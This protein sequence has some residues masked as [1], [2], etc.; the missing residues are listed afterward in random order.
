MLFI[1]TSKLIPINTQCDFIGNVYQLRKAKISKPNYYLLI[2][3]SE[4]TSVPGSRGSGG[5]AKFD[6]TAYAIMQLNNPDESVNYGEFEIPL[7]P[8]PVYNP[9]ATEPLPATVVLTLSD[10]REERAG[11]IAKP[12]SK[13]VPIRPFKTKTMPP[14]EEK[15]DDNV[16][17]LV[18]D[19]IQPHAGVEINSSDLIAIYV[20]SMRFIPNICGIIKVKL[21]GYTANMECNITEKQMNP[22]KTTMYPDIESSVMMPVYNQKRLIKAAKL[23]PS[24]TIV[25]TLE[26]FDVFSGKDAVLGYFLIN[27]FV[28][29]STGAP[30]YSSKGQ[31]NLNEGSF[32]LPIFCESPIPNP[33]DMGKL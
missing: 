1:G 12:L 4:R 33:F 22:K 6:L 16:K 19:N 8:A 27:L 9:P 17:D 18:L 25:G 30:I 15:K 2:Q 14:I 11:S 13:P 24:T 26:I 7:Y 21:K 29:K 10:L 20:D 23:N 5:Q 31:G 28:E 3:Y 32:Q